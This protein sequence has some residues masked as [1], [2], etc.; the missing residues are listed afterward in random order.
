MPTSDDD[1]A[2][3]GA[4]RDTPPPSRCIL[5]FQLDDGDDDWEDL[6]ALGTST[7]RSRNPGQSRNPIKKHKRLVGGKNARASALKRRG[8][9]TSK[10]QRLGVDL[11]AVDEALEGHGE[12]LADKYSMK[13][14]DVRQRMLSS[15]NYK[16]RR[17]PSLYNAK[18]SAIMADMN[19]SKP[20]FWFFFLWW[21]SLT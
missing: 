10:M 7:H 16:T 19:A 20:F 2:S 18:I 9:K 13:I 12:R 14:K 11:D 3:S 6:A 15:S 5:D 21:S 1:D 4:G 8:A 17:K